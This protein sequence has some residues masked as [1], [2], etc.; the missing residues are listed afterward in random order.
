MPILTARMDT[1]SGPGRAAEQNCFGKMLCR[2]CVWGGG[3]VL[4]V[5]VGKSIQDQKVQCVL[6]LAG[7]S[8]VIWVIYQTATEAQ[9]QL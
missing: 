5:G 9:E 4:V 6:R 7:G 1:G 3:G 2:V 8:D